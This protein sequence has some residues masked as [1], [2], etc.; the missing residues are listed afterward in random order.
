MSLRQ[1]RSRAVGSRNVTEGFHRMS[2]IL[3][4]EG[5][6]LAPPSTVPADGDGADAQAAIAV[7]HAFDLVH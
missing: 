4:E 3:T 1:A 2:P 5:S 7:R 6:Q